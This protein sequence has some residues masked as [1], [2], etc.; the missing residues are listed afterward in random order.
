MNLPRKSVLDASTVIL[1]LAVLIALAFIVFLSRQNASLAKRTSQL[2]AEIGILSG[3]LSGPATAV[4][5]DI[6]PPFETVDLQGNRIRVAY[7]NSAR[8]LLYIFSP[9]CGACISQMSIWNNLATRAKTRNCVPLG[10][11]IKPAEVTKTLLADL[12]PNFRVI[13]MPNDAIQRSYRVVAEPV[14]MLISR[15]GVIDWVYYGTLSEEAVSQILS[16][17]ESSAS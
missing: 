11:S 7:D 9:G 12:E 14:V 4:V 8:Y 2:N 15:E 6:V 17:I 16:R 5:G 1:T 10:I 13:I 3:T